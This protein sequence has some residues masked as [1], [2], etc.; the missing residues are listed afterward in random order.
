M[1]D[2]SRLA[3]L[4]MEIE[5]K[6]SAPLDGI[7]K[8]INGIPTE[9]KIGAT[10]TN[11]SSTASKIGGI[12]NQITGKQIVN[13]QAIDKASNVIG[14]ITE[15]LKGITSGTSGNFS[16]S[17]LLGLGGG[18]GKAAAGE[19]ENLAKLT[20]AMGNEAEGLALDAANVGQSMGG[21]LAI[22]ATAAAAALL[23]VGVAAGACVKASADWETET[24]ELSRASQKTGE[25]LDVLSGKVLDL[26]ENLGIAKGVVLDATTALYKMGYG[27]EDAIKYAG[28]LSKYAEISGDSAL[29]AAKK[30][31]TMMRSFGVPKDK[32]ENVASMFLTLEDSS[33][34]ATE[35]LTTFLA[36]LQKTT[37]SLQLPIADLAGLS[38]AMLQVG[39]TSARYL[40]APLADGLKEMKK[41]KKQGETEVDA[42]MRNLKVLEKV[43]NAEARKIRA[44]QIYGEKGAEAALLLVDN[45]DAVRKSITKTNEEYEKGT[46]LQED[47]EQKAATF[48]FKL[49]KIMNTLGTSMIEVG[50]LILPIVSLLTGSLATNLSMIVKIGKF[51]YKYFVEPFVAVLGVLQR[52]ITKL[53]DMLGLS[54]QFASITSWLTSLTEG[55]SDLTEGINSLVGGSPKAGEKNEP[56]NKSQTQSL[57]G[58]NRKTDNLIKPLD[59]S[60]STLVWI[61]DWLQRAWYV[62]GTIKSTLYNTWK[63]FTSGIPKDKNDKSM[64]GDLLWSFS[65]MPGLSSLKNLLPSGYNKA[66]LNQPVKDEPKP[67]LVEDTTKIEPFTMENPTTGENVNSKGQLVTKP[68]LVNPN[69]ST[70]PSQIADVTGG[71]GIGNDKMQIKD[72]S[73]FTKSDNGQIIGNKGSQNTDLVYGNNLKPIE[74]PKGSTEEADWGALGSM[75]VGGKFKTNGLIYGHAGEPIIPAKIAN[76]SQLQENLEAIIDKKPGK[77]GSNTFNAKFVIDNRGAAQP[78]SL[79]NSVLKDLER[80]VKKWV[81]DSQGGKM[82]Y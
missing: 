61:K 20:G 78:I 65:N 38:N 68:T 40:S 55:K 37:K 53:S 3:Q 51:T 73:L 41:F 9:I 8:K 42:Y 28:V 59:L 81:S 64:I 29:G 26:S 13:I 22:G 56:G 2:Y 14:S 19:M 48:N 79:N 16:I 44:Q 46:N 17:N 82:G 66:G 80:K 27:D 4:S 75:A 12:L 60:S 63:Y 1:G 21:G 6:I 74:I 76:S 11:V 25:E 31:D 49:S 18:A 45:Q 34:V 62:F 57:V 47:Y 24:L 30:F 5:D 10:D 36:R 15:G 54:E 67:T 35:S 72:G 43:K 33:L 39:G 7:L 23:A 71:K 52:V 58:I 32:M 77:S 50:D 70:N 69:P